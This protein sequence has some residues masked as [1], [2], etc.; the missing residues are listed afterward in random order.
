M[1]INNIRNAYRRHARYYDTLFGPILHRGRQLVIKA[2]DL[3]PGD[4]VLEVGVG[5]GLS[6]PLYPPGVKVTGIDVSREMLEIAQQRVERDRLENVEALL[7]MDAGNM[8]LANAT[9]NKAVAMYVMSVVPDPVQVANEMRRVCVP[10]GEIFIVNHFHSQR[11]LVRQF[12]TLLSPLS[13]LAGFRPNMDLNTFVHDAR[14]DVTD[15]QRANLFG[16]WKTLRCRVALA[17]LL[18]ESNPEAVTEP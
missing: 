10:S 14:L 17:P 8:R 5:T 18:P 3:H 12:E 13:H 15:M 4:H 11:P 7:E 1:N 6:L 16:Y 2:M 9:F